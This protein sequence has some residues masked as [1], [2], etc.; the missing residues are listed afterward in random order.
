M[1]RMRDKKFGST[2]SK[3]NMTQQE[4]DE[5]RRLDAEINLRKQLMQA[6][7]KR[8]MDRNRKY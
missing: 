1:E 6:E 8:N 3:S 5:M 7:M 2:K 4:K